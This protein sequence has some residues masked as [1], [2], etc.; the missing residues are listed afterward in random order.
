[1]ILQRTAQAIKNQD[2]FV[3]AIEFFLVVAGVLV[4]LQVDEWSEEQRDRS[5]EQ[6]YLERLETDFTTSLARTRSLYGFHQAQINGLGVVIDAWSQCEL[7]ENDRATMVFTLFHMGKLN[8]PPFIRPTINEL[9]SEGGFRLILSDAVK[10]RINDA[11]SENNQTQQ[12]HESLLDRVVPAVNRLNQHFRFDFPKADTKPGEQPGWQHLTLDFTALCGNETVLND[13]SYIR[14]GTHN[15]QQFFTRRISAY[16]EA[17]TAI[18]SEL[19]T[20][21]SDILESD[22]P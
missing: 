11:I 2:W 7:T 16:E 13:L 20:R 14:V 6:G 4:A 18:R 15:I 12:V 22:A 1:M 21:F 5:L 9:E 10:A 3:V 19:N 8:Q 17:L